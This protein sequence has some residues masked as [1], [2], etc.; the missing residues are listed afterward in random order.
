MANLVG[1]ICLSDIPKEL[2]T[3]SEKNKKLYLS[4][5]VNEKQQPDPYGNTHHIRCQAK[6][7]DAVVYIGNLKPQEDRTK[8]EQTALVQQMIDDL[9]F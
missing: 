9:P 7:G 8:Q 3:A 5:Y 6:V 1:S 2:I 4:I